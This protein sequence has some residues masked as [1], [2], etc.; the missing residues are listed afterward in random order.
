MD[1][2][3]MLR[4]TV[5]TIAAIIQVVTLSAVTSLDVGRYSISRNDIYLIPGARAGEVMP[6]SGF[7]KT[8]VSTVWIVG[9]GTSNT[10]YT[11]YTFQYET[12]QKFMSYND[13]AAIGTKLLTDSSA[14]PFHLEL[15]DSTTQRHRIYPTT[16]ND[17]AVC[18]GDK[19][20]YA[21]FC[22]VMNNSPESD[23]IDFWDFTLVTTPAPAT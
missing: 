4:P 9:L 1:Y 8:A 15:L 12:S 21:K 20:I 18:G 13:V 17:I 5:L 22:A 19:D 2:M 14:L 23:N 10:N 16:S 3:T 11:T 6:R 7:D